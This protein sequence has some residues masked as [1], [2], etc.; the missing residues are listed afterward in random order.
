[1]WLAGWILAN[2]FGIVIGA[3]SAFGLAYIGS[4]GFGSPPAEFTPLNPLVLIVAG[5]IILIP[6]ALIGTFQSFLIKNFFS[7]QGWWI[8][9]T[10]IGFISAS[11]ITES[12]DFFSH[13]LNVWF[14]IVQSFCVGSLQWIIIRKKIHLVRSYF[15]ILANSIQGVFAGT[16]GDNWIVEGAFYW[17]LGSIITGATLLWLLSSTNQ[18]HHFKGK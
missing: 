10:L 6:G 2:F 17:G 11:I 3:L 1:M 5:L 4:G 13:K 16:M 7:N 15:W 14:W 8:L 18:Q 9:S 12:V